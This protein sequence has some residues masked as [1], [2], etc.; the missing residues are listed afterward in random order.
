MCALPREDDPHGRLLRGTDGNEDAAIVRVPGGKALVQTVDILS[1]IG[2]D[3]YTFGRI[4][5]ANAL[6]DV[7]AMGGEPWCAMNIAFFPTGPAAEAEGLTLDVLA[8]I[9]R[10]GVD[11]IHEAGAVLAG[12]HTVEDPEPKYGLSVTGVIDPDA[13]A[14]NGGLCPGDK[15]VLTKPIG[16]GILATA[17]KARWADWEEA[18]AEF[19]GWAVRLNSGAA[20]VIR[21]LGLTGATDIT[22]FGLGGHALEMARAS[23]ASVTLWAEAVPLMARVLDYAGDGMVPGGTSANR[24]FCARQVRVAP[25]VSPLL[26]T[27][28]FDA[29]TSGGLLLGVPADKLDRALELLAA[30]GAPGW[31]VGEVGPEREDGVALDIA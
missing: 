23:M 31:V 17:A 16:T 24:R 5:A 6:S 10:G 25:T 12:G 11:T 19:C 1:P 27:V 30:Y 7:Y 28:I 2:N 22:G 8:D 15:L 4:A 29:Q 26:E 20:R 13:V 14:V 3:P 21:E 9:L 18:E